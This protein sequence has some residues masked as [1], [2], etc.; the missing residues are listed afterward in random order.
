MPGEIAYC[1]T[2]WTNPAHAH[3]RETPICAQCVQEFNIVGLPRLTYLDEQ[4]FVTLRGQRLSGPDA[5]SMGEYA[6]FSPRS[7]RDLEIAWLNELVGAN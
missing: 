5:K 4:P 7:S 1:Q 2:C 3:I 6:I